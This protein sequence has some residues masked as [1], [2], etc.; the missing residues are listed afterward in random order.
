MHIGDLLG[1]GSLKTFKAFNPA[2][3]LSLKRP[4]AVHD[5]DDDDDDGDDDDGDNYDDDEADDDDD[6]DADDD[7]ADDEYAADGGGDDAEGEIGGHA[8]S[9][10]RITL[11]PQ[12]ARPT[13]FA[14]GFR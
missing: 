8:H 13:P 12:S 2:A 10:P 5:D 7:D 6:G 4:A 3:H 14:V 9:V 11:A 1:L